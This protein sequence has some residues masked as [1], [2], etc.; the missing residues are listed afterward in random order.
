M[1][2]I[3]NNH[4]LAGRIFLNESSRF[5]LAPIK[6]QTAPTAD[7]YSG[8]AYLGWG[9][10]YPNGNKSLSFQKP[11]MVIKV[12]NTNGHFSYTSK[13]FNLSAIQTKVF[14]PAVFPRVVKPGQLSCTRGNGAYISSL[15]SITEDTGVCQVVG[16]VCPAMFSADDMVNLAAKK[17]IIFVNQTVFTT[18]PSSFS[19]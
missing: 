17:C 19:H 6:K 18:V 9:R 16:S 12:Q 1:P 14:A 11:F 4:G 8:S 10:I 2:L 3:T 15:V 7:Q 5:F 13:C